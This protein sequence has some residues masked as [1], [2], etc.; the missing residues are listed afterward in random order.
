MQA[1]TGRAGFQ[2]RLPIRGTLLNAALV[3]GAAEKARQLPELSP[4]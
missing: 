3:K 4:S 2:T 1:V